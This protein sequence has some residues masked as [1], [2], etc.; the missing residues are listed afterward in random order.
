M[1]MSETYRDIAVESRVRLSRNLKNYPFPARLG[2]KRAEEIV[3]KLKAKA[4]KEGLAVRVYRDQDKEELRALAEEE[5]G[6][7][8]FTAS[9]LPRALF[10]GSDTAV[11]VNEAD[12]V[13]I[14]AVTAGL[15]LEESYE[16]AKKLDAAILGDEE[17]A[18]DERLGYVTSSPTGLGTA[19]R[20]SVT[21]H[22]PALG[23]SGRI[24]RVM[25][26]AD[27]LGVIIR[28]YLGEGSSAMGGLY[29]VTNRTTLGISEEEILK[30]IGEVAQKLIEKERELRAKGLSQNE[31]RLTDRVRRAAAILKNA[32]A[33]GYNETMLLL[34]DYRMGVSLGLVEGDYGKMNGLI[35]A[36][37][38]SVIWNGSAEKTELAREHHRA[39]VVTAALA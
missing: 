26:D 12:H 10:T 1:I 38:P 30:R 35:R 24:D 13:R 14:Q 22:L 19:L 28:G 34:S 36:V 6:S 4:E 8:D 37:Q 7:A 29:T 17:I 31:I 9:K 33:I 21:L 15:S 5:I 16:K 23:E 27:R 32:Y 2:A 11:M 20:A 3:E 18:F 39:E 25:L